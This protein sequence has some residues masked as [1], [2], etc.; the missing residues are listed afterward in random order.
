MLA[1]HLAISIFIVVALLGDRL[2][3][4]KALFLIPFGLLPDLD[5]YI[6]IHRA[7]AHNIFIPLTL[8][9]G[10]WAISGQKYHFLR[11]AYIAYI[12]IGL[13]A[14]HILLDTMYNGVFLL[15]P[16]DDTAIRYRGW[17]DM[18]THGVTAKVN[19]VVVGNTSTVVYTAKP[20]ILPDKRI[21]II[22]NGVQ[23]ATLLIAIST[24]VIKLT[25]LRFT[26]SGSRWIFTQY[27]SEK[28]STIVDCNQ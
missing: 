15:Y 16:F 3:V 12:A 2:D 22:E 21:S 13:V 23:L 1:V 9:L 20:A 11:Y 18:T 24:L 4:R 5:A 7:T 28:E 17:V 6:F 26:R 25:V 27:P 19:K 10:Y 14:A 8:L